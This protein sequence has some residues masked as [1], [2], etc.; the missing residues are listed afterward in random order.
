MKH[1]S[2]F[3]I[4]VAT[5]CFVLISAATHA[6][7][8]KTTVRL[9]NIW[10][11]SSISGNSFGVQRNPSIDLLIG[12]RL[13]IGG[14]PVFDRSFSKNTGAL[15]LAKY[16]LVSDQDSYN[17]HFRLTAVA[18]L[19]R[20][21]NQSLTKDVLELEKRM[22]NT[23][24]N[25]EAAGFCEMRYNGWE[26]STGVGL[27]YRFY[28][29]M[30]VRTEVGLCYYTTERTSCPELKSFH[31][32]SGT[33]LRLAFGLGWSF[34]KKIIPPVSSYEQSIKVQYLE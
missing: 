28:C 17:G 21:H 33:S 27:S 15:F 11:N 13:M 30:V 29:G 9:H 25:D 32:E 14:G 5:T 7:S 31:D 22:A 20:M 23:M 4:L 34:G 10:L 6:Q 2:L 12:Q 24:R 3:R 8:K 16:Y 19:Q 18:S 1:F 26:A